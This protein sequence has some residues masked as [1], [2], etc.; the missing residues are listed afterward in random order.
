MYSFFVTLL[1]LRAIILVQLRSD[2][3]GI[4]IF[5]TIFLY[6]RPRSYLD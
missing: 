3:G 1:L 6:H 2:N 5:G 4:C